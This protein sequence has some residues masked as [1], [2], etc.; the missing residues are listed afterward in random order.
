MNGTVAYVAQSA[1][2]QSGTVEE[3]V[4]F[5]QKII[6]FHMRKHSR[7]CALDQSMPHGDLT[8]I[9]ERDQ[10]EWGT[11]AKNSAARAAYHNADIYLLDN[12]LSAVDAHT[13]ASLFKAGFT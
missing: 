12:P 11:E 10:H 6:K 2:F 1:W 4:L 3:N 8:E 9:G 5:R 13:Q 7:A